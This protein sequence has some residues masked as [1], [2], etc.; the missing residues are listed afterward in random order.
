MTEQP[1]FKA[2]LESLA[3]LLGETND[4]I[5]TVRDEIL[6]AIDDST[7]ELAQLIQQ[8]SAFQKNTLEPNQQ[9]IWNDGVGTILSGLV[10]P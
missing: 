8:V 7:K 1:D 2:E 5:D 3:K 10:E 6:E 4:K 9:K